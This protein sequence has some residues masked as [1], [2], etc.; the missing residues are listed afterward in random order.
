MKKIYISILLI[1]VFTQLLYSSDNKIVN[2]FDNNQILVCSNDTHKNKIVSNQTSQKI[3]FMQ[4]FMFTRI[5]NNGDAE[6]FLPKDCHIKS[7]K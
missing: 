4:L 1:L 7:N 5:Y 3:I 2:A 6:V